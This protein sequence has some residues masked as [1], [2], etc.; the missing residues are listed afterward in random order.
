MLKAVHVA[1]HDRL[2]AEARSYYAQL[3]DPMRPKVVGLCF[4]L[5]SRRR[6]Q[7]GVISTT[8][9]WSLTSFL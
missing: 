9:K 8:G 4:G 7:R 2:F 6:D 3:P 5:D 1:C